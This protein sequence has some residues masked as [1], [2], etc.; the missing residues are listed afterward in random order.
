MNCSGKGKQMDYISFFDKV[1]G[2]YDEVMSR[3]LKKERIQKYLTKFL[4]STEYTDLKEALAAQNI[5]PAFRASHSLKGVCANLGLGTLMNS[6]SELC[7]AL[8]PLVLPDY[9]ITPMV[10]KVDHDYAE[11]INAIHQLIGD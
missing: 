8:R 11:A 5:E 1:G 3:L 4:S 2:S 10:E 6:S 7:E 9:D